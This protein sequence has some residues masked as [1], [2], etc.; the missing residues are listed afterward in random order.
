MEKSRHKGSSKS[1]TFVGNTLTQSDA[2]KSY[3]PYNVTCS[4]PWKMT[5]VFFVNF[6]EM[7]KLFYAPDQSLNWKIM[8][9]CNIDFNFLE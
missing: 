3:T 6:G 9:Q 8:N 1:G 5:I 4:R 7:K 2:I